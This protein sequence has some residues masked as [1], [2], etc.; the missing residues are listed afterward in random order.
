MRLL[1]IDR[2]TARSNNLHLPAR[3][4]EGGVAARNGVIYTIPTTGAILRIEPRKT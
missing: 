2:R 4:T 3:L 1:R